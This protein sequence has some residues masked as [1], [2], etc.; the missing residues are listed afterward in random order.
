MKRLQDAD[1]LAQNIEQ[2]A[3]KGFTDSLATIISRAANATME[4]IAYRHRKDSKAASQI[5]SEN[6]EEL[7]VLDIIA[8]RANT[9][10]SAIFRATL[11]QF[12]KGLDEMNRKILAGRIQG[13]TE[14]EL[15]PTVG[16]KAPAVHKR[17]VKIREE[18]AEL[19]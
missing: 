18:L 5:T 3:S 17:I 2:R 13:K 8:A 1:K 10:E 7:D 14:R 19:L 4:G 12:V 11:K 16:I 6:G 9:E 15:A